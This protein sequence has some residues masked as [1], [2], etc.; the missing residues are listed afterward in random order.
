MSKSYGNY[1]G[2]NESAKEIFGKVMSVSD[3][4]MFSYYELLTDEDMHT[5]K[6]MHPME[7]KKNLAK[8]IVEQYHSKE[9]AILQEQEFTRAFKEKGFPSDI[10][11]QE[12]SADKFGPNFYEV[13][14]SYLLADGISMVKSRSE[15]RRKIGEGAVEVNGQRISSVTQELY[16]NVEYKIRVGRKFARVLIKRPGQ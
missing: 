2:I 16:T 4:L 6:T 12:I 14:I 3:E 7:A 9:E 10:L 15:A 8:L 5:V 1:I 13:P 11:L